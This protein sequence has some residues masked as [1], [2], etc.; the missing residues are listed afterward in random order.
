MAVCA[1]PSAHLLGEVRLAG[2]EDL[3]QTLRVC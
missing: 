1:P 3:D 2:F